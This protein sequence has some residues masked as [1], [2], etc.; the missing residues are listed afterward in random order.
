M[1]HSLRSKLDTIN[2]YIMQLMAYSLFETPHSLLSSRLQ[3]LSLF[4][5]CSI[6][7]WE[8]GGTEGWL[9]YTAPGSKSVCKYDLHYNWNFLKSRTKRQK[10][11]I[12]W[13]QM[14]SSYSWE[15]PAICWTHICLHSH[16]LNVQ[17]PRSFC[18]SK[19]FS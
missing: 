6:R 7:F 11:Y 19:A 1:L 3:R 12:V 9:F 16:E 10:K 17:G 8:Y 18:E 13:L 4:C 14:W 2:F 5:L 15:Y